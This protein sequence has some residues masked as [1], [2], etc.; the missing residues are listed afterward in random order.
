MNEQYPARIWFSPPKFW[1]ATEGMSK[2]QID[3]WMEQIWQLA[4]RSDINA[5]K[6][7]DFIYV[8]P[9][10]GRNAA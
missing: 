4:E 7:F 3:G 1:A 5:L 9:Y 10:R 8:G 2:D 6:Q